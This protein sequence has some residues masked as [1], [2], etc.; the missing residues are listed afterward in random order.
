MLSLCVKGVPEQ[1]RWVR[2]KGHAGWN[3]MGGRQAVG[4]GESPEFDARGFCGDI[5]GCPRNM[6]FWAI[7]DMHLFKEAFQGCFQKNSAYMVFFRIFQ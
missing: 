7:H 1:K 3:G 4:L 6:R 5:G 2:S